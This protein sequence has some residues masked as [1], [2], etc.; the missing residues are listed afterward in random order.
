MKK[1]LAFI[2]ALVMV[3]GMAAFA[4]PFVGF[5]FTVPDD[6]TLY[7]GFEEGPLTLTLNVG[8][9]LLIPP[10]LNLSAKYLFEYS[11]FD[12]EFQ[13]WIDE[14]D[15]VNAYPIPTIDGMG[16]LWRGTL[17]IGDLIAMLTEP[18]QTLSSSMFDVYGE[19]SF[20]YDWT[21]SQLIPTGSIGF[22]WEPW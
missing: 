14:I 10:I 6:A 16:L 9:L 5:D 18:P 1:A 3:W 8:D 21:L 2:I 7:L 20:E 13:Y 17:H 15:I 19:V 11:Y 4:G 12:N 22:Y